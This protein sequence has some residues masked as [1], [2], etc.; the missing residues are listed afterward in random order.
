MKKFITDTYYMAV[1]AGLVATDA[2]KMFD[3]LFK[4]D[5][6]RNLHEQWMKEVCAHKNQGALLE[7]GCGPGH[8][9]VTAASWGQQVTALDRS[10]KML[11]KARRNT[12]SCA[13][14]RLVQASA[15]SIPYE[16]DYFDFAIA[17]SLI[18][19]V[20][21]PVTVLKEITRV[22]SPSGRISFL[23]PSKQMNTR[24]A[25]RFA[26]TNALEGMSSGALRTW[27]ALAKKLSR[28]QCQTIAEKAGLMNIKVKPVF[29]NMVF[30]VTG[31][32]RK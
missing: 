9:A 15:D 2:P 14:I 24:T 28:H 29:D 8:L 21:D 26:Q 27:A 5:W 23:V 11:A 1:I 16:N 19:V 30:T 13:S 10:G 18:N 7:V 17:A 6:Y 31:Q 22:V 3:I 20:D 32:P 25:S 12:E 4:L